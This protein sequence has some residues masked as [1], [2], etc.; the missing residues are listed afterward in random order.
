MGKIHELALNTEDLKRN[1]STMQ[2]GP[3]D[4]QKDYVQSLET[5]S[6]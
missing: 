1:R 5:R 4:L 6:N 3:A 2:G